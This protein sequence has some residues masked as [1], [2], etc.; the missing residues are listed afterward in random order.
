MNLNDQILDINGEI[1][2]SFQ[3]K[4]LNAEENFEQS[5]QN[6]IPLF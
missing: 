2:Q 5:I 1:V 4:E 6:S 3:I